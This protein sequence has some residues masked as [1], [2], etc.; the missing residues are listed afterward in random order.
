M[1]WGKKIITKRE[2][3]WYADPGKTYSY[4]GAKFFPNDLLFDVQSTSVINS[5][6]K[7]EI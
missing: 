7:F 2:V 1:V 6:K 5:V 4:S 3:A